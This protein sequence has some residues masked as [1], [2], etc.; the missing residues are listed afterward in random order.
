MISEAPRG[1]FLVRV[2]AVAPDQEQAFIEHLHECRRPVWYELR[3]NGFAS[4]VNL[5]ELSEMETTYPVSPPWRYL[6]VAHLE[7]DASAADFSAAEH[8]AMR[9][10]GSD[11][12]PHSVVREEH[13]VCTPNS[14]FGTAEPTYPD[15]PTGIDFL[16]ELIA[17]ENSPPSLTTY[18]DLMSRYIGPANGVLVER[19]TLHCFVALETTATKTGEHE[20]VPWNQL[21]LSDHWDEGGGLDWDAIYESLFREE[22]SLDL[23]DVWSQLPP[24]RDVSTEYRGRLIP[25]LCVR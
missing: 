14:C 22:F 5:F 17:V 21:H 18:H 7:S 6:M 12:P 10:S 15:A 8:E 23:D 13:M 16:I 24:I 9:S 25:E 4:A 11:T 20:A 19:G 1:G 3:E 2:F